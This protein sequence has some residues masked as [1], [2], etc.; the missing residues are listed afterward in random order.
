MSEGSVLEMRVQAIRY[1]ARDTHLV[2]LSAPTN[3]LLPA[4]TPGA[5]IDLHLGNGLTRSYS[6]VHSGDELHTYTVGIKLDPAS[7][8]GSRYVH[9]ELRVGSLIKVSYPRNHFPLQNDAP[10]SV[11]LAGG[12]GITPIWCMAQ[13][14]E[15]IGASWELWYSVR[16]RADAA[17]LDEMAPFI[18]NKV[19][20]HFDDEQGGF[21]N[22]KR[23]VQN[24]PG[25]AHLYCCGPAPMLD[26]YELAGA[27]RDSQTVHLERFVPKEAAALDGGFIIS[28]ARS[29][30]ELAVPPGMSV[31][32]V[33]L[34][35]GINVDFSCKE[36]IC[37]CCEVAVL[38]GEVDHR[39]A[40]LTDAE[41][42]QNKTM[43]VCCSGAKSPRLTLD[44]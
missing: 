7:R 2:E 37:G 14:L 5:H 35:N 25:N 29:G 17:F 13:H 24:A 22:L 43:M 38:D 44:L 4:V 23:I 8:G 32:Q 36:G 11:L 27:D 3:A 18:G 31:L 26:A 16:T 20:L 6:L 28:L 9:E 10:H 41:K 39:D 19:H 15:S 12:I 21:L 1:A 34:D 42:A 30:K 40:V 33:L